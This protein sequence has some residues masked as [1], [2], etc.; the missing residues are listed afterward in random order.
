METKRLEAEA[1]R[2]MPYYKR[3]EPFTK[4][5]FIAPFILVSATF[6]VGHFSGKTPLQTYAVQVKITENYNIFFNFFDENFLFTI[7]KRFRNFF[8]NVFPIFRFF[9]L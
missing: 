2:Q 5:G 6:F 7:T 4:R 1:Y 9:T 8:L 3:F